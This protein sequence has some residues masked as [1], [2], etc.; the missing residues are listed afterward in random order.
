MSLHPEYS[1]ANKKFV[2]AYTLPTALDRIEY[3]CYHFTDWDRHNARRVFMDKSDRLAVLQIVGAGIFLMLFILVWFAASVRPT[4]SPVVR[5]A[6]PV[7]TRYGLCSPELAKD[8]RLEVQ[9]WCARQQAHEEAWEESQGPAYQ[10]AKA[11]R[12]TWLSQHR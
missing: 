1:C 6:P 7:E 3:Q 5:Y 8:P 11:R 2:H 12:T 9:S 4:P 10:I